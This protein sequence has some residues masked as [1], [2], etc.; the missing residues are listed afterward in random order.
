MCGLV[1][2]G[3]GCEHARKVTHMQFSLN[4]FI[5]PLSA[6]QTKPCSWREKSEFET[7][8]WKKGWGG[9]RVLV[10]LTS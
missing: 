10:F 4:A 1:T 3:A 2:V 8:M 5:R 6:S 9:L 7:E